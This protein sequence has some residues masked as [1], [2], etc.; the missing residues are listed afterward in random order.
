ML[1]KY[2]FRICTLD[3]T[4]NSEIARRAL[5]QCTDLILESTIDPIVLARKLYSELII[6]A[7]IYKRVKDQA[8]RD[9]NSKCLEIILDEINDRVKYDAG[10]LTKFVDILRKKINRNDIAD[11]IMSKYEGIIHYEYM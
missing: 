8:S 9:T 10:I 5:I 11:K 6:S 4:M 7:N 3:G 2:I 1:L